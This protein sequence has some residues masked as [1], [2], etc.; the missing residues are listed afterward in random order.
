M[1]TSKLLSCLAL[2]RQSAL[3]ELRKTVRTE[4]GSGPNTDVYCSINYLWLGAN[5]L[6]IQLREQKHT[7]GEYNRKKSISILI[8]G[9]GWGKK[10]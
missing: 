9:G 7:G 10:I 5:H 4:R 2:H 3:A 6:H 8:W 1:G